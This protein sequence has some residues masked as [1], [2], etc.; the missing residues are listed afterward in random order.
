MNERIIIIR[1]YYE[2]N[3]EQFGEQLGLTKTAISYIESGKRGVTESNVKLICYA[4]HI[5]EDW[6]RYGQGSML[7][8]LSLDSLDEYI[9]QKGGT[10]LEIEIVKAYFELKP[11]TRQEILNHFKQKLNTIDEIG[12]TNDNIYPLHK[13]TESLV[14]ETE[15]K[16]IKSVLKNAPIEES[17]ALNSTE[18]IKKSI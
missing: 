16:Y 17:I 13:S 3:Q 4:F 18:E 10:E 9:K 5:N 1:N 11:S 7:V 12:V 14:A 15:G 6:L 2:M 8:K